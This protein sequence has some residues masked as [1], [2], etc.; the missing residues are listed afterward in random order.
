MLN[1]LRQCLRTLNV[2]LELKSP[3]ATKDP[4]KLIEELLTYLNSMLMFA[5]LESVQTIQHLLRFML[6]RN[7]AVRLEDYTRFMQLVWT[8]G[9]PADG[10][11]RLRQLWTLGDEHRGADYVPAA[12]GTNIKLFEPMVIR[13]LKVSRYG[14]FYFSLPKI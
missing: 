12:L 14:K 7:Y 9:D 5:P 1:L 2:L 11:T 4:L 8:R 13:C 10:F 6:A 3:V